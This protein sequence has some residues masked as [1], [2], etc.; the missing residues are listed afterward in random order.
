MTSR[1]PA[2][3]VRR[4]TAQQIESAAR[5]LRSLQSQVQRLESP[6][7]GLDEATGKIAKAMGFSDYHV[8]RL[9]ERAGIAPPLRRTLT[10][11][12]IDRFITEARQ[13]QA[14]YPNTHTRTKGA[15]SAALKVTAPKGA[16][17]TSPVTVWRAS[18]EQLRSAGRTL[19]SYQRWSRDRSQK[20]PTLTELTRELALDLSFR[21]AHVK[22]LLREA[23]IADPL[24]ATMGHSNIGRF[25]RAA[26]ISTVTYP[27]P[28]PQRSV[29]EQAAAPVG[30]KREQKMT[31]VRA[32][33]RAHRAVLDDPGLTDSPLEELVTA[34]ATASGIP[35]DRIADAMRVAGVVE[36]QQPTVTA[37]AVEIVIAEAF[38]AA[39]ADPEEWPTRTP[40]TGETPGRKP[41]HARFA[42]PDRLAAARLVLRSAREELDTAGGSSLSVA[43][44]ARRVANTLTFTLEHAA[45][46]LNEAGIREPLH[47]TLEQRRI[48]RFLKAAYTSA[49]RY[50]VPNPIPELIPTPAVF[51]SRG[52]AV[53]VNESQRAFAMD[54]PS[55]V[56]EESVHRQAS[57]GS[58]QHITS[59]NVAQPTGSD[60]EV[61]DDG[62]HYPTDA[63]LDAAGQLLRSPMT[64]REGVDREIQALVWRLAVTLQFPERDVHALLRECGIAEPLTQTVTPARIYRFLATS[65][66]YGVSSEQVPERVIN[67][68]RSS[69]AVLAFEEDRPSEPITSPA[70]THKTMAAE[71]RANTLAEGTEQHPQ[72]E[73]QQAQQAATVPVDLGSTAGSRSPARRRPQPYPACQRLS[74]GWATATPAHRM[75]DLYLALIELTTYRSTPQEQALAEIAAGR[76]GIH[77]DATTA[78]RL[79]DRA[80]QL[81]RAGEG[82][83]QLVTRL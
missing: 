21:E 30:T 20:P 34:V 40:T 2:R 81:W 70:Q 18:P 8:G 32:T 5:Y 12:A 24:S 11:G 67:A 9:L 23:R 52:D 4:A 37:E 35:A 6:E 77:S 50:P 3:Q 19:T 7:L 53:P 44:L 17:S 72:A 56:P 1:P 83:V 66:A 36:P 46:L 28:Y 62:L 27:G 13:A 38:N 55:R 60:V 64:S 76:F 48:N 79:N 10:A 71:A 65:V 45:A 51:P 49:A 61:D 39:P 33:F 41:V 14:T 78:A 43:E 42:G 22:Q 26:E 54:L 82:G 75:A 80:A 73:L 31:R 69:D 63:Q 58:V 57:A 74:E 25:L 29:L 47:R 59:N 68:G 16:S 15:K